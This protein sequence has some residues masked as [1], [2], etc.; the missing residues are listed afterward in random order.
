MPAPRPH[1]SPRDTHFPSTT[2]VL[3]ACG[4]DRGLR[5]TLANVRLQADLVGA[6]VLLVVNAWPDDLGHDARQALEGL[7]DQMLFEPRTGKS[8]ALNTAIGATVSE[9]LAFTDDDA[10]PSGRWLEELLTPLARD[11]ELAGVG[12][13]VEP[14][15]P[16]AG[17]PP[18]YRRLIRRHATHFLGPKHHLGDDAREYGVPSGGSISPVPLGANVAWRRTWLVDHPYRPDLGPNR[19]TGLRGGEDT[20]VALEIL[21]AGGRI[22]YAPRAVVHHPVDP[23]RMTEAFVTDGYRSQ[24]VEYARVLTALGRSPAET[25]LAKLRRSAM[26]Q[27]L[28]DAWRQLAGPEY[29]RIKRG[30]NRAFAAGACAEFETSSGPR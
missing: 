8:H 21:E 6:Q 23:A 11:P 25:D 29:R 3:T 9:V 27:P 15:F 22:A 26:A 20:L 13:P 17:S 10:T 24:G 5:E 4:D 14:V 12:G 2:V 7:A 28:K 19:E 30:C 16:A 1:R 18:W